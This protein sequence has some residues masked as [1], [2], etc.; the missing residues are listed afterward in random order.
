MILD[1]ITAAIG[2]LFALF[3]PGYLLTIIFFKELKSLQRIVLAVALSIIIDV[4]IAIFL[5]YNENMKILAGG[6]TTAN[7]WFY[8][9]VISSFLLIIYFF[10]K[11]KSFK[12]Q[13]TAR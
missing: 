12:K 6:V 5:G 4:G 2:M 9:L 7:I 11:T 10:T 3:I 8:S 13:G 1:T